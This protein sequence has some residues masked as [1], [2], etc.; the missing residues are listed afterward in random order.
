LLH[1]EFL[2]AA[3]RAGAGGAVEAAGGAEKRMRVSVREKECV[4]AVYMHV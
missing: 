2:A 1:F 4:R 3:A